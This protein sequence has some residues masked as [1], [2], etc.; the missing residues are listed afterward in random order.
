[1]QRDPN[2]ATYIRFG[3]TSVSDVANAGFW[4]GVDSA[5]V[6]GVAIGGPN[7]LFRYSATDGLQVAGQSVSVTQPGSVVGSSG[8]S[9]TFSYTNNTG[10][11]TSFN[12]KMVGG[13][14]GGTGNVAAYPQAHTAGGAGGNSI[15]YVYNA[16]GAHIA[17]YT[18][19]G[20]AGGSTVKIFNQPEPPF[21]ILRSPV[22]IRAEDGAAGG[23]GYE[24]YL[25]EMGQNG[26]VGSYDSRT[27]TIPLGGYI[28]VVVGAA[29]AGGAGGIPGR[30]GYAGAYSL[31]IIGQ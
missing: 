1:M 5:G 6:A 21:I 23:S 30:A 26:S 13:G 19:L 24:W 27:I 16:A 25:G 9:G 7:G 10:L 28:T 22:I 18:T 12:L 11:F 4:I 2:T 15:A 8:I 14:G 29:G 3:K 17:T 20:G 31:T